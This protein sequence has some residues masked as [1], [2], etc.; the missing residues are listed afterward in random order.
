MP[1]CRIGR[2]SEAGRGEVGVHAVESGG[3][4]PLHVSRFQNQRH[5]LHSP[6]GR[7]LRQ[8][9]L[10]M[11]VVRQVGIID[12]YSGIPRRRLSVAVEE[13]REILACAVCGP[14]FI[15]FLMHRN[16]YAVLLCSLEGEAHMNGL[17][18]RPVV[19]VGRSPPPRNDGPRHARSTQLGHLSRQ[20]LGIARGVEAAAGTHAAR[21]RHLRRRFDYTLRKLLRDPRIPVLQNG[22]RPVPILPV[23]VFGVAVPQIEE[24]PDGNSMLDFRTDMAPG[25]LADE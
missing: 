14:A 6:P 12:I 10:P 4:G 9:A 22:M 7:A 2:H 5:Q 15:R 24:D 17:G 13:K 23:V 18:G 11:A 25:F 3:G 20:R 16:L 19:V 21:A 1:Q 8:D